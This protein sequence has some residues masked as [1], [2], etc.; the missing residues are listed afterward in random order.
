M[1]MIP[2]GAGYRRDCY[3]SDSDESDRDEREWDR[4][5]TDDSLSIRM[6]MPGLGKEDVKVV[7][8]Q[9]IDLIVRGGTKGE[10]RKED[11]GR[12]YTNAIYL[13]KKL[14]KT[15]QIKAEMKNGVLKVMVPKVKEEDR[16]DVFHHVKV[17]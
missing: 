3:M 14:Y 10:Y 2:L 17:E 12:K 11:R 16:P 15:D 13:P 8:E 1:C 4:T 6:D 5:E 7:V 9:N